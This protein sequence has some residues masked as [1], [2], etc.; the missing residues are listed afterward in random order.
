[1]KNIKNLNLRRKCKIVFYLN[2]RKLCGF[3]HKKPEGTV[4]FKITYYQS[5]RPPIGSVYFFICYYNNDNNK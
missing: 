2:Q 5:W 4:K 1:M 3:A